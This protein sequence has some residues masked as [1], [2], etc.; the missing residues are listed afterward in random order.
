M[1]LVTFV[2]VLVAAALT[3]IQKVRESES[4]RAGDAV[5]TVARNT[6]IAMEIGRFII[7]LMD[8]MDPVARAASRQPAP[9]QRVSFRG[10]LNDDDDY[11]D[12]E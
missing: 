11:D 12:G 10:M 2:L 1:I 4:V 5:R 8:M 6:G 7:R 9:R 3:G